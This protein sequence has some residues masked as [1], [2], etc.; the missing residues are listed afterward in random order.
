MIG[1]R[2]LIRLATLL[3][4]PSTGTRAAFS[5]VADADVP[6]LAIATRTGDG[7]LGFSDGKDRWMLSQ[8]V[9]SAP[10]TASDIQLVYGNFAAAPHTGAE[11][12]GYN[13]LTIAAGIEFPR[14]RFVAATFNGQSRARVDGGEIVTTD[15]LPITIP[16][17]SQFRSR[18]LFIAD[19]PPFKWPLSRQQT[20]LD[21]E[22]TLHGDNPDNIVDP[23]STTQIKRPWHCV[24]PLDILG[25]SPAPHPAVAILGDSVVAGEYGKGDA[26]GDRGFVERALADH[27]PWSNFAIGGEAASGF[28][29]R[30]SKR[31]GL[32]NRHFTHVICALGIAEVRRGNEETAKQALHALWSLLASMG[33]KV[34]QTTITTHTR[35][36]DDWTTVQGQ[37]AANP[38]FLAGGI[39]HPINQWIR[40]TP[41]PLTG[42]FDPAAIL[43]TGPDSG[44]WI[45]PDHQ[46]ITKDGP[47]LNSL[48]SEIAA[49]CIDLKM[50]LR[51]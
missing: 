13:P 19:Q 41:P 42:Y 34:F 33:L 6:R 30:G 31:L 29:M 4:G 25:R 51:P 17:G 37:T 24:G 38:N 20:G 22:Y 15:P 47:H 14:G 48:G 1:R 28:L 23:T 21:D 18:T 32:I 27:V 8:T 7:L 2:E 11:T 49:K 36:T 39:Y 35:S 12:P 16:G 5:A 40:S 45:A 9:H 44:I 26:F 46:P 3:I 43:E 10:F 50:L